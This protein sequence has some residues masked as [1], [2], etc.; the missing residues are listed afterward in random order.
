MNNIKLIVLDVDGVLTNGTIAINEDGTEH[1]NFNVKDGLGI[2]LWKKSGKEIG[3]ISG[4]KGK[5]VEKRLQQLGISTYMLGV[6]KKG[7]AIEE[8]SNN[9]G[10]SLSEVA[11][12]GDDLNDLP[13]INRVN[14]SFSPADS[15]EEVKR[16]VNNITKSKGGYGAV[17]EMIEILLKE[18]KQWD[19]LVK[20]FTEEEN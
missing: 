14:R 15:V 2:F 12:M 7:P 18:N 19:P 11:F 5:L 6:Q 16:A 4:R 3:V 13:A 20:N 1:R 9:L 10:F 8:M 17:R